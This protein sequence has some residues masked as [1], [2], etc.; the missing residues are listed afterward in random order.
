MGHLA[1]LMPD[2]KVV[3]EDVMSAQT[4]KTALTALRGHI[5]GLAEKKEHLTVST[6]RK[7]AYDEAARDLT[8]MRLSEADGIREVLKMIDTILGE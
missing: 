2:P 6:V 7:F 5:E 3:Y 1:D 8:R 4:T